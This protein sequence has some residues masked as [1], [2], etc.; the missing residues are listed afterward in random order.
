M[1]ECADGGVAIGGAAVY[2]SYDICLIRTDAT[3]NYL[4]NR[5]YG[6]PE[7]DRCY[8][9]NLLVKC[10]NGNFLI[11]GYTV[12]GPDNCDVWVFR[13]DEN[14]SQ[15]WNKAYGGSLFD[16]PDAVVE[17]IPEGFL[18]SVSTKSYGMGETDLWL[19]RIDANGTLLW[20]ATYGGAYSDTGSSI[21]RMADGGF[22]IG[23]F[24]AN[25]GAVF[26]DAWL[27]RTSS[28]GTALWSF[29]FGGLSGDSGYSWAYCGNNSFI[30]AGSTFSYGYGGTDLWVGKVNITSTITLP[31]PKIPGF[32]GLSGMF[33]LGVAAV[34]GLTMRHYGRE[35][36][37]I[38]LIV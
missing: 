28:N 35:A 19:L 2:Y 33:A 37:D 22:V 34:W 4:W 23:G 29:T 8:E 21:R 12:V 11:A 1:V 6:G 27:L 14:G 36:Q 32:I 30:F 25:F 24:T 7:V 13:T 15:I 18:I 3:G 16:R 9:P 26:G 17:C 38:Q 20:N 5:T 10:Q 31:E